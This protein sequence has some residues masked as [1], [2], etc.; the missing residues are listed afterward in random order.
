MHSDR[1]PNFP[2]PFVRV[3]TVLALLL[4]TAA[5]SH[6]D[7]QLFGFVRGAET[8]PKNHFEIYQ[9][10]TLRTG[11]QSGDYYGTD[12][13]TEIEYGFTDK[14]QASFAAVQHYFYNQGVPDLDN[15]NAYRFGGVELS[16][17]YRLLSPFKD[18]LGLALRLET[19]YLKNDE[20]DGLA[21]KEFFLKPEI[22]FQKDFLDDTLIFDLDLA[23][24]WA[25][26]KQ[27]AEEYPREFSYEVAFGTAYRF[28]PNWFAGIEAHMRAEYPLFDLNFFEHRAVF[29][30]PSIHY[31]QK[32][33]WATLTWNYQV[34]GKGVDE[35]ANG[36]TFAEEARNVVRL[37]VGFNF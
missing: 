36:I 30:G 1:M 20:V 11:K 17:K 7:E 31:A 19:G 18:P 2:R 24:E 23:A 4:T 6:A 9:F 14:F 27:P 12:F 10:V 34:F 13:D 5:R 29:S 22:D 37:K 26:G 21:Q 3:A 28:A 25:W 8:L 16:G 33:W 32:N 15:T 35:P